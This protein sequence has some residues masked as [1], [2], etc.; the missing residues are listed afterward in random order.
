MTVFL[1]AI[2]PGPWWHP[3]TFESERPAERGTRLSVPVAGKSRI[4]FATGVMADSPPQGDF[5]I[6]KVKEIIDPLP[7]LGLS[8]I[9][10]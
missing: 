8:L 4:G 7:P 1:E 5:K 9:H 3:L 6:L 2:V 10:I